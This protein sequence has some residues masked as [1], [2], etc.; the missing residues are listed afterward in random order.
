MVGGAARKSPQV[1][2]VLL[3]DRRSRPCSKYRH[4][5]PKDLAVVRIEDRDIY[6][7]KYDSPESPRLSPP[8]ADNTTTSPKWPR[9]VTHRGKPSVAR[10]NR[11][12]EPSM[13]PRLR[14]GSMT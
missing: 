3:R 2:P 1:V 11:S 7:G 13:A 14:P 4:Y 9:T 8:S 12:P 5:R 10:P 6:L